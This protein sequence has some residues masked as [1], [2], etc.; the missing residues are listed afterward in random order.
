[1]ALSALLSLARLEQL[2]AI[3]NG[4]GNSTYF[5][6]DKASLG[7]KMLEEYGVDFAEKI[8]AAAQAVSVR[9]DG[10][11][12]AQKSGQTQPAQASGTKPTKLS[13]APETSTPPR[14]HTDPTNVESTRAEDKEDGLVSLAADVGEL[15]GEAQALANRGVRLA[16]DKLVEDKS[17]VDLISDMFKDVP[18]AGTGKA[19]AHT[20]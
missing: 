11:A 3:A 5:F 7:S 18:E 2:K 19:K 16:A 15:V 1:M 4:E 8:K 9:S 17:L 12:G 14:Q 6:G 20:L 10:A 13:T